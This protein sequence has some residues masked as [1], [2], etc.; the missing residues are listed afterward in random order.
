MGLLVFSCGE[1]RIRT[2]D[3][4]LAGQALWPA[5]LIPRNKPPSNPPERGKFLPPFR[6]GSGW[7]FPFFV[8]PGRVELPTSTLSV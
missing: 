4:L 2:D 1:Y 7:G 6:G 8:V 3:I 5:E